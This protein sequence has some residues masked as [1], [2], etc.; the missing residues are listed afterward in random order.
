MAGRAAL[1]AYNALITR[2]QTIQGGPTYWTNFAGRVYR[3]LWLP[4]E[5]KAEVPYVCVPLFDPSV[6]FDSDEGPMIR[7]KW[8]Q[9]VFI[10]V[11]E[12]STDDMVA[13]APDDIMNA[14]DDVVKAMQ[15]DWKLGGTV[16]NSTIDGVAWFSAETPDIRYGALRVDIGINCYLPVE[17]LGP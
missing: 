9:P 5:G 17:N 15:S 12:T 14:L 7:A 13:N 11:G 10:F 1:A 16:E 2:L 8:T 6:Q 4:E 3:P